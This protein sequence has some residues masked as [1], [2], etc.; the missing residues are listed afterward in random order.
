M[1]RLEEKPSKAPV[2]STPG[3]WRWWVGWFDFTHMYIY[4]LY[5]YI[6]YF[7]IIYLCF[8]FL[9]YCSLY[10]PALCN[11]TYKMI[12]QVGWNTPPNLYK[13]ALTGKA[14]FSLLALSYLLHLFWIRHNGP[15]F[16]LECIAMAIFPSKQWSVCVRI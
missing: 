12:G 10:W 4:I 2:K 9:I 16:G 6:I 11:D 7:I 5:V 1:Y 15:A 8:Y 14:V 3:L 13:S